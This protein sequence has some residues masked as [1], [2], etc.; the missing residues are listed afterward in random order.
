MAYLEEI[1]KYKNDLLYELYTNEKIIK[2]LDEDEIDGYDLI[3]KNIFPYPYIPNVETEVKTYI[4]FDVY[5]PR[6]QDKMFKTVQV[7]IN[8]FS[9][10]DVGTC[11][12]IIGDTCICDTI[13]DK[14]CI[15]IDKILNGSFDY[16]VDEVQLVS[17]MPYIPNPI[18]FGK[19]LIYNVPNFNQRRCKHNEHKI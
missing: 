4:A 15:E 12:Q 11:T 17:V 7:V 1:P 19:T 2:Y 13:V 6:V 5:V 8:L 3:N 10:K 14:L 18:F 16:G 9:H